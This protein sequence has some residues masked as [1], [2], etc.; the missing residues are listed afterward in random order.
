MNRDRVREDVRQLLVRGGN[1]ADV[2]GAFAAASGPHQAVV[3]AVVPIFTVLL[4]VTGAVAWSLVVV[5]AI[6]VVLFSV[7]GQVVVAWSE[8]EVFVLRA[9]RWRAR[10]IE[11]TGR[12]PL[13]AAILATEGGRSAFD[14]T[15]STRIVIGGTRY[16]LFGDSADEAGRLRQA[17]RVANSAASSPPTSV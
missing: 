4:L 5:V 2:L 1:A 8:S 6:A 10:P 3:T 16:W 15:A 7:I 12:L 14:D 17:W 13:S 11:V 9:S